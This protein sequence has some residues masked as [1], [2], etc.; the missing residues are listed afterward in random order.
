MELPQIKICTLS[1]CS[2]CKT[3][4]KLLGEFG[5]HYEFT[6]VDLLE[7]GERAAILDDVKKFNPKCYFPSIII[8]EKV[9]VGYKEQKIRDALGL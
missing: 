6:D 2:H 7:G 8:E 4:T 3:N 1:T 5:V 9:I